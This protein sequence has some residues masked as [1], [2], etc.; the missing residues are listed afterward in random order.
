MP[1]LTRGG[2]TRRPQRLEPTH[3]ISDPRFHHFRILSILCPR[4]VPF[5]H[6]NQKASGLNGFH[7]AA[8]PSVGLSFSQSGGNALLPFMEHC[9]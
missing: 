7:I 1:A 4:D 6:C 3:H 5:D 8:N 2:V 9:R